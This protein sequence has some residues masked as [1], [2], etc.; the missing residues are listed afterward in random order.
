MKKYFISAAAVLLTCS[1]ACSVSF[2]EETDTVNVN[3]TIADK[4]GNP[5]LVQEE[6]SVT[7][8]DNDGKLTIND[9]LYLAHEK[10]FEGGAS[11]GYG[12]AETQYGLSL[13]KLWGT[14]NGGSYGY[15]VNNKAAM[16]LGDAVAE[17]DF[18]NAF[19]Y[20]DTSAW[21]DTYC[22]FDINSAEI[23]SGDELKLTLSAAGYDEQWNPVTKKVE[24]AA[25]IVNGNLTT[26]K[27][28]AEGN[29]VIRLE[30]TGNFVISAS[31]ENMILVP[32]VCVVNVNGTA[33]ETTVSETTAT[34]EPEST[35]SVYEST[36]VSVS[37][38]TA[39]TTAS[40]SVSTA[41]TAASAPKTGDKSISGLLC[42][43]LATGAAAFLAAGRKNEK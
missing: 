39:G 1:L 40:A 32:P 29:V 38:T 30:E 18:V 5:V 37:E 9:A 42:T 43:F 2:A 13:T 23:N 12:F 36:S 31:S 22:W 28:D 16:S 7:D 14:E 25:I 27:T 35:T 24:G 33:A 8:I 11:A 10:E 34:T 20:T 3:V 6:I 4:D 17:G 26:Y 41:V 19:V 15:Y 21:S